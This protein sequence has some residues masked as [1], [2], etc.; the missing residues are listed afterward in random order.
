MDIADLGT[1]K[2]LTITNK[3]VNQWLRCNNKKSNSI[4]KIFYVGIN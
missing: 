4:K 2:L 1:S 3:L